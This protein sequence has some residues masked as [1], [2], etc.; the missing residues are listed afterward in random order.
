MARCD[1]VGWVLAYLDDLESDFSALHRVDDMYSMPAPRFFRLACRMT[2]YAGVMQVRADALLRASEMTAA[3]PA[4][5]P[6]PAP[7]AAPVVAREDPNGPRVVPGDRSA[8]AADPV[9]SSLIEIGGAR[10]G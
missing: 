10:R 3:A 8:L 5:H 7:R 9:F 2:A 6:P 4:E 1:E